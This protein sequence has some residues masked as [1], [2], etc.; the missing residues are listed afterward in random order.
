MHHIIPSALRLRAK[1]LA[2][3]LVLLPLAACTSGNDFGRSIGLTRDTP[4]EFTVTTRAPLSMP[5]SFVL[6]PPTP[7][8]ARP[9]ERS[10]SASA[11]AALAPQT[12]LATSSTMSAGER[13]LLGAAGPEVSDAVRGDINKQAAADAA[14]RGLTNRLMFWKTSPQPG[15]VVDPTREAKRLRE[16][17]ALGQPTDAGDTAII[18]PKATTSSFLKNL[19]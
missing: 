13:A 6:N 12:A 1:T 17:A 11:E 9:Q 14:N 7:G 8:V 15:V 2:L 4:D 19:F 10:A 16:N 18:Q 5:P 3:G